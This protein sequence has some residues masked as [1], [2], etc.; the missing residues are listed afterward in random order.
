LKDALIEAATRVGFVR[1]VPVLDADGKPT[2]R[3]KPEWDG[4][5]GLTGYLEWAAV[6][7]PGHFIPQLGRVIINRWISFGIG[8]PYRLLFD[9]DT[10]VGCWMILLW[11]HLVAF[12][13]S[14]R[15]NKP[16]NDDPSIVEP[17]A[18]ATSAA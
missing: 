13:D 16:E 17:I 14:T 12:F 18:I 4:D 8:Y 9:N 3:T 6:F 10:L 11:W 1:E 15:V 7:H 5:G 2:G